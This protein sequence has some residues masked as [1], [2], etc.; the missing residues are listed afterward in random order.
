[1]TKS[2]KEE[3]MAATVSCVNSLLE[4]EKKARDKIEASKKFKQAKL[5]KAKEESTKTIEDF[6][7]ECEEKLKRLEGNVKS[8]QGASVTQMEKDIEKNIQKL[9]ENYKNHT[10]IALQSILQIVGDVKIE[11]HQ[12]FKTTS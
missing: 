1:M 3:D 4:A 8:G 12:N 2:K 6:K 10:A 9:N 11:H 5:K 7:K